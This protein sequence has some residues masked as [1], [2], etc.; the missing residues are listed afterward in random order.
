MGFYVVELALMIIVLSPSVAWMDRLTILSAYEPTCYA[1]DR[2]TGDW[3]LFWEYNACLG[4]SAR[5]GPRR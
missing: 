1:G 2:K 4:W 5:G 3:P